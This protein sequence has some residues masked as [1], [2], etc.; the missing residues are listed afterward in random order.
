MSTLRATTIASMLS[1]LF[2]VAP[3]SAQQSGGKVE[4]AECWH[5]CLFIDRDLESADRIL[6]PDFVWN[7]GFARALAPG[8]EFVAGVQPAKDAATLLNAALSQL[9]VEHELE[10]RRCENPG[11]LLEKRVALH[12]HGA[13]P[14]PR[15]TCPGRSP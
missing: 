2:M 11:A 9:A 5:Y 14:P 15:T 12:I 3:S 13:T 7:F 1:A 8:Q 4:M 10:C 6:S